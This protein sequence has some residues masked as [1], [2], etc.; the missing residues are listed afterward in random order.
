MCL[1]LLAYYIYNRRW[2]ISNEIMRGRY[3]P[4]KDDTERDLVDMSV[5]VSEIDDEIERKL[6]RD[7]DAIYEE[8]GEDL[9]KIYG[10]SHYKEYL[11]RDWKKCF[12]GGEWGPPRINK[13]LR[14]IRL[15][16]QGKI[17]F[18]S[19]HFGFDLGPGLN[20][21]TAV[22]YRHRVEV[23]LNEA[24]KDVKLYCI[25]V[26]GRNGELTFAPWGKM[27]LEHQFY[28]RVDWKTIKT[29]GKYARP[30]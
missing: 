19:Y 8:F 13:L 29:Q 6:I 30:W 23:R 12:R 9:K 11:D 28:Q 20:G 24:G 5:K 22:H 21:M 10:E 27:V 3:G 7:R 4:Q 1:A 15:A 16:K 18:E 14:D 26:T 2:S 17:T 25:P